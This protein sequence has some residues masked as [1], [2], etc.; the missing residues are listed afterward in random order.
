[1]SVAATAVAA[2]VRSLACGCSECSSNCVGSPC[3]HAG[4]C[5]A[6]AAERSAAIESTMC[7]KSGGRSARSFRPSKYECSSEYRSARDEPG[8]SD[9]PTSAAASLASLLP[10]PALAARPMSESNSARRCAVTS[11]ALASASSSSSSSSLSLFVRS[12]SSSCAGSA[13]RMM[14]ATDRVGLA[15]M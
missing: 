13:S 11:A 10:S 12:V 15:S 2:A 14:S 5:M 1:M 4:S 8:T 3:A 9:E 6:P 7:S